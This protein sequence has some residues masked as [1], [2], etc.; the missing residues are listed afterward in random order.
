MM[1][2][3]TFHFTASLGLAALVVCIPSGCASPT[4]QPTAGPQSDGAATPAPVGSNADTSS[5]AGNGMSCSANSDNNNTVS[6]RPYDAQDVAIGRGS[7]RF[8]TGSSPTDAWCCTSAAAQTFT[9]HPKHTDDKNGSF[10]ARY[11]TVVDDKCTT[12]SVTTGS[13]HSV[14]VN[15]GESLS[16]C[17]VIS[18]ANSDPVTIRF[19]PIIKV[20]KS[21]CS[22]SGD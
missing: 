21:T 15:P 10:T 22:D 18:T 5:G 9:L 20:A 11:V 6:I 4:P 12:T 8:I 1:M 19:D 16:F 14:D 13:G 17:A 2:T 7:T 3:K